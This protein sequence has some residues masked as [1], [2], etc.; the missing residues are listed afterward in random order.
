MSL[1]PK[2]QAVLR[3]LW[4]FYL[5]HSYP[6]TV[7]EIGEAF[8]IPNPNGVVCHLKALEAKG[9]IQ[10]VENISRG[11]KLVVQGG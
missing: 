4:S 11:I 1:T 10:R 6:P 9:R 2:Q 3:F 8:A 7:R 5:E